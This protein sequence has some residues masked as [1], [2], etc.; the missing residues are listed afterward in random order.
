MP[1]REPTGIPVKLTLLG[2]RKELVAA[3][4]IEVDSPDEADSHDGLAMTQD[5][6]PDVA[7]IW[8]TDSLTRW[9]IKLHICKCCPAIRYWE[10]QYEEDPRT[11]VCRFGG[12]KWEGLTK[13]VQL[14]NAFQLER[15]TGITAPAP[16][17]GKGFS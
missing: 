6:N 15:T 10:I 9:A 5:F 11:V 2:V 7:F 13:A 12:V 8:S 1:K 16:S 4:G 14:A 17:R 3:G